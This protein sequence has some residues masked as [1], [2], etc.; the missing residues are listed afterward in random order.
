[1]NQEKLIEKLQEELK[2]VEK[3]QEEIFNIVSRNYEP[4]SDIFGETQ[5]IVT[6]ENREKLITELT[7]Y[8]LDIIET[9]RNA[10][11]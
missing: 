4:E 10:N 6:D 9:E 8:V 7:A 2:L 3:L 5:F 1:V 11:L